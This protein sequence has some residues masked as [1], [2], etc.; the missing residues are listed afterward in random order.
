MCR[1]TEVHETRQPL[2]TVSIKIETRVFTVKQ[3]THSFKI[4]SKHVVSKETRRT[5]SD[6]WPQNSFLLR[7]NDAWRTQQWLCMFTWTAEPSLHHDRQSASVG[8]S[9]V[10]QSCISVGCWPSCTDFSMSLKSFHTVCCR[11]YLFHHVVLLLSVNSCTLLVQLFLLTITSQPPAALFQLLKT[12]Q[13]KTVKCLSLNCF[14][15]C[16]WDLQTTVCVYT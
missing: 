13:R 16:L 4:N 5:L 12:K 8:C 2:K 3:K 11:F 9:C 7:V 10:S 1:Q 6:G 15:M 14:L